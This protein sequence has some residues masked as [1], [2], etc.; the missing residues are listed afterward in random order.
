MEQPFVTFEWRGR[1]ETLYPGDTIG[2]SPRADLVVNHPSVSEL[3]AMVS[4]RRGALRALALRGLVASSHGEPSRQASLKLRGC[5]RLCGSPV[6]LHIIDIQQPASI[7]VLEIA[8]QAHPL[9]EDRYAIGPEGELSVSRSG[10]TELT[11]VYSTNET[12]Y[13]SGEG[14]ERELRPDRPVAVGRHRLTLRWS[15][16]AGVAGTSALG[17][18]LP[19]LRVR[20]NLSVVEIL[21]YAH[22]GTTRCSL[23]GKSALL[24]H[25]LVS[26]NQPSHWTE[27]AP[28]VF[29]ETT[30]D[31]DLYKL[32]TKQLGRLRARLL[33]S[34]I[35]RPQLILTGNGM[36]SIQRLPGDVFELV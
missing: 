6:Q 7:A 34:G 21:Q 16:D 10:V 27:I 8:R 4:L 2:R 24:V 14:V 17:R 29:D 31:T 30:Y 13:V 22:Q 1:Q 15:E 12:W 20:A 36:V 3:H 33:R 11:T 19:S 26:Q 35:R 5:I 23:T 18:E 25:A 9:V 32:W 28:D